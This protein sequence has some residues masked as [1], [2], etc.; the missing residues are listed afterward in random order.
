M[1]RLIDIA[2]APLYATVGVA[3]VLR[4]RGAR[5]EALSA[6][7]EQLDSVA[8]RGKSV[9]FDAVTSLPV[10]GAALGARIAHDEERLAPQVARFSEHD[11]LRTKLTAASRTSAP[12]PTPHRQGA[13]EN[14][15]DA[16]LRMS[17]AGSVRPSGVEAAST[18]TRAARR[19]ARRAEHQ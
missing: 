15:F 3:D 17:S 2:L 16:P 1:P 10:I 18:S 6:S 14:V 11:T 13:V 4:D 8:R 19:A 5:R 7:F 12:G 9:T